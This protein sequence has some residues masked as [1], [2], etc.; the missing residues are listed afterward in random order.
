MAL[1]GIH[2][3]N[4]ALPRTPTKPHKRK[5]RKD[6]QRMC[7]VLQLQPAGAFLRQAYDRQPAVRPHSDPIAVVGSCTDIDEALRLRP[8]CDEEDALH[9]AAACHTDE[10][11]DFLAS[12]RRGLDELEAE[13]S[14]DDDDDEDS[15]DEGCY[16]QASK[17]NTYYSP[18]QKL[19]GGFQLDDALDLSDTSTAS[20]SQLA[21]WAPHDSESEAE[22]DKDDLIF[23]LE[24]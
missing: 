6:P 2:F 14:D 13:A 9:P 20:S 15:E 5:A 4:C 23:Q 7:D 19:P 3:P 12:I 22:D 8:E 11:E 16:Y 24:M 17:E 18:D 21:P 1:A 10:P